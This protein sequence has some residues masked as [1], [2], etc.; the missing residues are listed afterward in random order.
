MLLLAIGFIVGMP[1]YAFRKDEQIALTVLAPS[2]WPV[3][4]LLVMISL[5]VVY[6]YGPCRPAAKWRWV[7]WGATASATIVVVGSFFFS[8]YASQYAHFNPLLGSLGAVTI[9][10]L[11]SYLNVLAILLGAQIN[12]ELERKAG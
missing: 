9:F 10:L 12:A 2:R 3:L 6:R 8:Y 11:W 7:T 1:P 4:I 5:S